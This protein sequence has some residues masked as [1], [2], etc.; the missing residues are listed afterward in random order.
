MAKPRVRISELAREDLPFLLSLWQIPEVM[1]YA[2]EFPG[3]RGWSKSEEIERAWQKYEARRAELGPE[4]TQMILQLED[5]TPVGESF[6]A[7]LEEGYTFGR[8]QKP[9]GISSVMGDIKLLPQYWGR[10]LGTEGMRQVVRWVFGDTGCELFIIPP[11]RHNPAAERVYEKAGFVLFGGMRS[12][13]NHKIMELT[14][15][16]FSE[17]YR[18]GTLAT[19]TDF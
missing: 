10:G 15:D 13:R 3:Y 14:R 19:R 8:W 11:H 12:W 9:A 7:P 4:Y 6:F 5:G 2:D 1:R 17:V 18:G 16:R